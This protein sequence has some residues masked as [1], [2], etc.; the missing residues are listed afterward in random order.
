M[1]F[2][3]FFSITSYDKI[4]NTVPCAI[5]LL[6]L[7]FISKVVCKLMDCSLPGS[8][9]HGKS[10]ARISEWVGIFFPRVHPDPGI[11][12]P[13]P[14]LAGRFFNNQPPGKPHAI[15]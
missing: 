6:F 1:L 13:S 8:F 12:S 10:K 14:A 4:L 3:R 11:K 15:E 5:E 9:T 2:F 7:W